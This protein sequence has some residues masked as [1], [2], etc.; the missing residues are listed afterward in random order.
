M[1]FKRSSLLYVL[2]LSLILLPATLKA[3]GL[4]KDVH[5]V[6]KGDTLWDISE[7]YLH[8]PFLW[9]KL[10]QWNDYIMNPHFIYPGNRIRL[11]APAR[12]AKKPIKLPVTVLKPEP[13]EE[14]PVEEASEEVEE[15]EASQPVVEGG[16]YNIRHLRASGMISPVELSRAGSI[17]DGQSENVMM[18][19]GDVIYLGVKEPAAPGELYSVF[20]PKQKIYHPVTKAIL[21]N[22]IEMLG[23]LEIITYADKVATAKVIESFNVISRGDFVRPWVKLPEEITIRESAINL[24]GYI[25]TAKEEISIYGQ[26]HVVYI[27]LGASSGVEAGNIF[28]SYK[29]EYIKD[30]YTIPAV[31]IGRLLV[32]EVKENSS[33]AVIIDSI[34]EMRSGT[35]IKTIVR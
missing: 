7:T 24:E 26:G 30:K 16:R 10:W 9:P 22:K 29:P 23:R 11:K 28:I 15:E 33:S 32:F 1:A 31:T 27:D 13:A 8:N 3:E 14:I 5:I 21:G 18:S 20:K 35:K 6:V 34:E 19:V 12:A 4:K 25:V 2:L 17:L